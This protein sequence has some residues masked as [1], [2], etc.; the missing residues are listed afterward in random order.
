MLFCLQSKLSSFLE[1]LTVACALPGKGV[2][3]WT[4]SR[5]DSFLKGVVVDYQQREGKRLNLAV[6]DLG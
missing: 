3:W 5:Q 4:D 2:A 1:I 6:I